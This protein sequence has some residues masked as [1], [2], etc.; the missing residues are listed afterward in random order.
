MGIRI[1]FLAL[2]VLAWASVGRASPAPRGILY[3]LLRDNVAGAPVV[4]EKQQ[5]SFDPDVGLRRRDEFQRM[6]G[7]RAY[8]LVEQAG[9]GED[10][11]MEER[12]QQQAYRDSF[13]VPPERDW[14]PGQPQPPL[15]SS[16]SPG[17][18]AGT[19]TLRSPRF[20]LLGM[21]L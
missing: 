10:G 13:P 1:T 21:L 2:C 3:T 12:R 20:G 9:L 14:Q 7:Y 11:R 5:W 17:R 15:R 8:N 6:H 16:R 18:A 19:R 4:H